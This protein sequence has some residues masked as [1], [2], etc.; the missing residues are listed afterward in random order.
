LLVWKNVSTKKIASLEED[1]IVHFVRERLVEEIILTIASYLFVFPKKKKNILC[2]RK[3]VRRTK[4]Q[5]L[6]A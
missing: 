6:M 1:I 3:I 2:G 5:K 4:L